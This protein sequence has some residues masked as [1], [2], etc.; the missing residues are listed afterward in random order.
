VEPVNQDMILGE[1][2]GQVRELV[3]STNNLTMKMDGLTEKVVE[4]GPIAA[5]IGELKTDAAAM[6]SD[7]AALK[8]SQDKQTGAIAILREILHSPTVVW[9]FGAGSI[10]YLYMSG[11]LH[12]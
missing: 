7:I 4:L 5:Q 10:L 8:A 2:R 9:L 11:R 6:K 12:P 3:H 1:L